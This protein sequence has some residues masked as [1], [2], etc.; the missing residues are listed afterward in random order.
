MGRRR[1]YGKRVCAGES[2]PYRALFRMIRPVGVSAIRQ[3]GSG[4]REGET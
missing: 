4:L 2:V 3:Y 1:D